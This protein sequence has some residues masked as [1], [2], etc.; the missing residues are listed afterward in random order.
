MSNPEV[1]EF[2]HA[3]RLVGA[4]PIDIH[5]NLNKEQ[6]RLLLQAHHAY[7]H[8]DISHL[9]NYGVKP[10]DQRIYDLFETWNMEIAASG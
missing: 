7:G 3:A 9:D 6:V 5:K 2:M 10:D 4:L 1:D 8:K